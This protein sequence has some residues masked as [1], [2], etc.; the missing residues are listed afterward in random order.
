LIQS[1]L[2]DGAISVG[3]DIDTMIRARRLAI[4]QDSKAD[5]LPSCGPSTRCRSRARKR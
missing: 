3:V 2:G 4:N 5:R 1:F